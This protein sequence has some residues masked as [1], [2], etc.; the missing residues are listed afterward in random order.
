MY[1]GNKTMTTDHKPEPSIL[2][3]DDNPQN[4]ATLTQILTNQGY[5]VHPAING[6]VAL[7]VVQS[8]APDVI[9]LDI[10]MPGLDGYEVCRQLKAAPA[11]REIPV[12]FLS[13]L[14]DITDKV[15]AF[16]V[17]GVDYITKPFQADEVVVRVETHIALRSMQKQ[18]QEQNRELENYR[19]RLEDLVK[20]RTTELRQVNALLHQEI[21]KHRE[22]ARSLGVSEQQYRL[23]AESVTDGIVIVQAEQIVFA[24]AAFTTM[25][26]FSSDNLL[27]Q[28]FAHLFPEKE[29][30]NLR[31]RLTQEDSELLAPHGKPRS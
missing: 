3:V 27:Q 1:M 30:A 15:K 14:D 26:G 29:R 28:E 9:L 12:L 2:I 24:N 10:R 16:E 23:L 18:L 5:A 13:A 22:T 17:G 25:F 8:M 21:V 20:E 11:T 4:L 7:T 19:E 6:E 31:T